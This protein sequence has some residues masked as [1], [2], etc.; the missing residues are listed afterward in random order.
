VLGVG[1]FGK[2][3]SCSWHGILTGEGG[4]RQVGIGEGMCSE[5]LVFNLELVPQ[6]R[7]IV[8]GTKFLE[9]YH[10]KSAFYPCRWPRFL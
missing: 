3:S 9:K 2:E 4:G 6:A 1:I 10:L 7:G 8:R 5:L